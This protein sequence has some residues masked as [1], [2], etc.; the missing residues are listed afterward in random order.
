[1]AADR[2]RARRGDHPRH[3]VR[4][5]VLLRAPRSV[6]RFFVLVNW[7]LLQALVE[8]RLSDR[9]RLCL[10]REPAALELNAA[11]CGTLFGYN[12]FGDRLRCPPYPG[13]PISLPL[14]ES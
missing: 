5:D 1:V 4:R 12:S 11:G 14:S 2:V 7:P 13:D 10:P 3:H 9:D 8:R 6:R